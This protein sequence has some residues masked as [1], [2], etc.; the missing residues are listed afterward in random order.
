MA[1]VHHAAGPRDRLLVLAAAVL[2]STGGAAVKACSLNGWQIASF[3]SGIAALALLALIPAARKRWT[4]Q[5][6]VIGLAY[7]GTM[8]LFVVANKM[9]TAAN[10]IFLQDTAPLYI[11]LL[12]PLLL[13]E[14]G[15]RRDLFFIVILAAGM[16][17]FFVGDQPATVTAPQPVLGNT[18]ALAAGICW[19]LTL[20]GLRRLGRTGQGEGAPAAV[21]CGNLIAFLAVLPFA[22]PVGPS[23]T[24]DWG[25]II[26]LGVF[27]IGLAYVFLT[28]G[29]RR[30]PAL[31]ASLLLLVEPVLNPIW[32]FFA[33]REIPTNWAILGGVIVLGATAI[34]A[35]VD[36]RSPS[37]S[38]NEKN[39][40]SG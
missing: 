13:D 9:T 14:P 11:L 16:S 19:A 20:I 31:E 5:T 17:L 34:K 26:F 23:T 30:V 22:L 12:G 33:H 25:S 2:F 27:Q 40:S 37:A 7:A 18:L 10:T 24:A 15:R 39:H 28:R 4:R 6:W 21:A 35:L 29:M 1:N 3:R 36:D 32:A 8:I 38:P